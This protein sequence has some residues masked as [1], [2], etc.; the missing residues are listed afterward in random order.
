MKRQIQIKLLFVGKFLYPAEGEEAKGVN[1]LAALESMT[2]EE[3]LDA[4]AE[5][6][7]QKVLLSYKEVSALT[8]LSVPTI[9]TMVNAGQFPKPF[10]GS[11]KRGS[12]VRFL[13]SEIE[14]L[15]RV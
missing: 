15:R 12:D 13:R 1:A 2:F 4:M 10:L 14:N 11:G 9:R 3:F 7:Q 5:R 8:G 6:T